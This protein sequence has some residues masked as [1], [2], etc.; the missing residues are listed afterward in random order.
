MLFPLPAV[1]F[2]SVEGVYPQ[3]GCAKALGTLSLHKQF[4]NSLPNVLFST[5][6]LSY[7][8]LWIILKAIYERRAQGFP[9]LIIVASS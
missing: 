9:V 5:F 7:G 3:G 4:A 6:C 2:E 1:D 8:F